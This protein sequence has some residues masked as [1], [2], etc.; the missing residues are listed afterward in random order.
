MA[1]NSGTEAPKWIDK[2]KILKELGGGGYGL[3][4]LV[5]HTDSPDRYYAL[6]LLK[7]RFVISEKE[8]VSSLQEARFKEK[9][10]FLQEAR[11][12]EV[13]KGPNFL[14]VEAFGFFEGTPYIVTE[15]IENGSLRDLLEKQPSRLLSVDRS[16][17]ILSR[18]GSALT[19][20][21]Q[22]SVVHGDLKPENILLREQDQALLSDFGNATFLGIMD[23]VDT[24]GIKGTFDY[25][26]PEQFRSKVGRPSDQYAL[27]CIAYELFTGQIPFTASE[28]NIWKQK[29][30]TEA[31]RPLR[32]VNPALEANIESAT[33]TALAKE[34]GQ[35]HT[36][37]AEFIKQLR[38]TTGSAGIVIPNPTPPHSPHMN[39]APSLIKHAT[40]GAAT[41]PVVQHSNAVINNV[42]AAAISTPQSQPQD[43]PPSLYELQLPA[44]FVQL[45]TPALKA[46]GLTT[47]IDT[48]YHPWSYQP[49]TYTRLD[50][51][52][53]EPE[54]QEP[55]RCLLYI[56]DL[57]LN[58]QG[59]ECEGAAAQRSSNELR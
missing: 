11:F 7:S 42:P 45:L 17:T 9:V 20:I 15:H 30:E 23:F 36:D 14:P 52:N 10:S 21:H 25:M 57:F 39:T 31:P 58:R 47:N 50:R 16:L 41:P 53:E 33:L 55:L 51:K 19:I 28:P 32:E 26:S 2:Y 35:R 40:T 24:D 4:Y 37:V 8:K 44:S 22:I 1:D 3:V 27:G 38:T 5:S 43:H 46:T 56:D 49:Y 29:H 12:L 48:V 54:N 34:P 6:K 59:K 13:I 18:I